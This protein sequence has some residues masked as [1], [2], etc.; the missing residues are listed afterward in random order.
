MK[1]INGD[2]SVLGKSVASRCRFFYF[3]FLFFF[4]ARRLFERDYCPA[5][6]Q[7][8][9]TE[10]RKLCRLQTFLRPTRGS[11]VLLLQQWRGL[12]PARHKAF[13]NQCLLCC[14]NLQT[15]FNFLMGSRRDGAL[16]RRYLSTEG[17]VDD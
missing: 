11:G 17:K 12:N 2:H 5:A 14:T 4:A 1:S 3:V 8:G 15:T 16:S 10:G 13:C 7:D 9:R 6:L